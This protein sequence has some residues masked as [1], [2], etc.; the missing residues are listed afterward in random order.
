MG[1]GAGAGTVWGGE[2]AWLPQ[3]QHRHGAAL[4]IVWG[5]TA[6]TAC[7][8]RSRQPNVMFNVARTVTIYC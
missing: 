6:M 2:H 7:I 8:Q 5:E 1:E 3:V 4:V